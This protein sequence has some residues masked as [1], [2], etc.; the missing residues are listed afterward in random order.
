[1]KVGVADAQFAQ[2]STFLAARMGLHFPPDR[3]RDLERGIRAAAAEFGFDSAESCADWLLSSPLAKRQVEILA[4]HLTVGETYFFRERKTFEIL[5]QQVL[6]GLIRSSRDTDRHLR[7]W[8]AGCCTGEEPYSL[9]ILLDQLLPDIAE[10]KITLLA[11]DINPR[12][13]Q[14]ASQG[15]YTEWSFRETPA[16]IRDRYFKR[17]KHGDYEILPR[18]R[19]LV[20]FAYLNLAEDVFPSLLNDTNAMDLILCRNV[21]MY[22]APE[23]ARKVVAHLH[24]SVVEGGWLIVSPSETSQAVFSEFV[25]VNFP[26]AI[27]YK[28]GEHNASGADGSAPYDWQEPAQLWPP[29]SFPVVP[30]PEVSLA[31]ESNESA[32][33]AASES[34]TAEREPLPCDEALALY[35][36]GHYAQAAEKLEALLSQDTNSGS[37]MALLARVYANQ[38]RLPEALAWCER[39]VATDKL[40]PATHFLRATILLEQKDVEGARTTLKRA[41]YL[42]PTFV[43]AHF[44]LGNLAQRLG[45]HSEAGKHFE[46]A[47]ALLR[48][49]RAE[50]ALPEAEGMTAGRLMDIIRSTSRAEVQA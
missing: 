10:Y 15:V 5:E 36:Q 27:L 7:I 35:E 9:A 18:I 40:N 34:G 11:T 49:C 38:G 21:L 39:A 16:S 20:T 42:E 1:M 43:L 19:R 28:K 6:P 2:L 32:L 3:W 4:S 45:K 22:F 25:T 13:L 48:R 26:G 14:K 47:L 29:P 46:N 12:F 24:R 30:E 44:A 31:R 50:E 33:P 8:S 41:V 17:G 23:Q 37:A